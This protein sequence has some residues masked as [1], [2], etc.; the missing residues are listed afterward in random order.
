MFLVFQD[1][2]GID[3]GDYEEDIIAG[4]PVFDHLLGTSYVST[5]S[6]ILANRRASTSTLRQKKRRFSTRKPTVTS[7][8]SIGA[9]HENINHNLT[10]AEK[11][12]TGRV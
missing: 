7:Q 10:T 8:A 6:G 12:E 3:F 5:V 2:D 9:M 11:V 1:D 4:S